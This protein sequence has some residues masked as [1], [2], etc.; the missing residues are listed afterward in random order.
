M[1][2]KQILIDAFESLRYDFVKN[3]KDYSPMGFKTIF[4]MKTGLSEE[5]FEE[6]N[7]LTAEISEIKLEEWK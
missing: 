2:Y 1:S 5:L 6:L 7:N 3:Y 4:L